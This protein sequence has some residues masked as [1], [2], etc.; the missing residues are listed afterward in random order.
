MIKKKLFVTAVVLQALLFLGPLSLYIIGIFGYDGSGG[1][2]EHKYI[3]HIFYISLG[4]FASREFIN[5]AVPFSLICFFANFAYTF[6]CIFKK[7]R[8]PTTKKGVVLL[9]AFFVITLINAMIYTV[10]FLVY[11]NYSWFA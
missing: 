10:G 4:L 5:I 8:I 7:R 6:L 3:L 1:V 9:I 2:V 11:F